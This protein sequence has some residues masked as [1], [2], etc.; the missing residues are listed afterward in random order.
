MV[1]INTLHSLESVYDYYW[2]TTDLEIINVKTGYIKKIWISKRGYPMVSLETITNKQ[3]NVPIHKIVALAFIE[4]R[5]N[6]ELIEHLNDNKLDYSIGNLKFSNKSDNGKRAFINGCVN[7]PEMNF[8]II[9]YDGTSHIG[10][11]KELSNTFGISRATLY[12]SYYNDRTSRKFKKI[13]CVD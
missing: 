9:M 13:L 7:R 6:Y 3:V 1:Q 12:D 5:N 11:M 4:N 8:I 10:T 2:I